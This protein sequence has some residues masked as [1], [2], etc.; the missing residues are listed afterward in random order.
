ML[1]YVC[2][3]LQGL[4]CTVRFTQGQEEAE[5]SLVTEVIVAEVKLSETWRFCVQR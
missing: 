2:A 1:Q 4:Q 3:L 5:H